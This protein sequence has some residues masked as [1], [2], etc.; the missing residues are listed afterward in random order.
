MSRR[1]TPL[2]RPNVGYTK[3]YTGRAYGLDKPSMSFARNRYQYNR[4]GRYGR[5]GSYGRY[6]YGGRYARVR[7]IALQLGGLQT[8][9]QV[10]L[11]FVSNAFG[12]GTY[13]ALDVG[14][15]KQLRDW[16][17][18]QDVNPTKVYVRSLQCDSTLMNGSNVPVR[19]RTYQLEPRCNINSPIENILNNMAPSP[20]VGYIDPTT[21]NEFKR[22]FTITARDTQFIKAGQTATVKFS[23]FFPSPRVMTGDIE[24]SIS[25]TYSTMTAVMLCFFDPAPCKAN[26][27]DTGTVL[28]YFDINYANNYKITYY[29]DERALP[30]SE[31]ISNSGTTLQ[32][33][34]VLTDL[35]NREAGSDVT[36]PKVPYV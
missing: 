9:Q 10:Y 3:G 30:I 6:G 26:P 22:F 13:L 36:L 16:G 27:T 34:S 31:A 14:T 17:I 33:T 32:S 20:R 28:P 35:V 4:Y 18:L 29:R 23:K 12:Q 2:Y 15:P 8:Y 1:S 21:S 24:G 19:L 11:N 7:E 5:L 25:Y